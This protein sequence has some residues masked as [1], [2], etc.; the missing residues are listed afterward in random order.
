MLYAALNHHL[1]SNLSPVSEDIQANL[2]VDNVISGCH[3]EEAAIQYNN[4]ART[5]MAKA[6]FNL[7]SWASNSTQ[8][9]TTA[10]QDGVTESGNIVKILGLQWNIH[11]DTLF[12]TSKNISTNT[13]F[14]TKRDVLQDSSRIFDPLGFISPVIIQAKI[15]IQELWG[16]QI[17]WDEMLND[18]LRTKWIAIAKNVQDAT[19]KFSIPRY[20]SGLDQ[21]T[22]VTIHIFADASTK[23]YG[24]VA[25]SLQDN[26]VSFIMSKTRVAPLKHLTLPRL[27]LSA[28]LLASRLANFILKSLQFQVKLH[29][30]SDSQHWITSTKKLQ[31]FVSNRVEEITTLFPAT[32]WHFCPTTEN[33]AD[34]LTRGIS[35]QQLISSNLWKSGPQWLA[36]PQ[37]WPIWP[38]TDIQAATLAVEADTSVS[39]STTIQ[40]NGLCQLVNIDKY[41]NLTKL[42]S[43]TAFVLRFTRNCRN[44][45][46]KFTGPITPAELTQAHLMWIRECQQ[47]IFDKEI[48]N[49]Q[50][51]SKSNSPNRL[52]LVRQL[53]LFLDKSGLL[54]CGGG[55]QCPDH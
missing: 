40:T 4:S 1:A 23:A 22:P 3:S 53:C 47:E 41:S 43:V 26:Q 15:F 54:R 48:T 10:K 38:A 52:P 16:Q 50:A 18:D 29:L 19:A 33:P 34:L 49:L 46:I 11:S 7:R 31:S 37:Q 27:E 20:Y 9:Q 30:W 39:E 35:S 36:S 24:A 42:F 25:Y 5:I 32:S 8:L 55:T 17:H 51:Q 6:K 2:Y 44:P 21:S 14:I 13:P 28:A 45:N 12:L